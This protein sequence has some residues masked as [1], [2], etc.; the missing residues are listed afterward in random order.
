MIEF[1]R[2]EEEFLQSIE[3]ARIATSHADIP[4]VK[5]VSFI[6]HDNIIFIA[7]DYQTRTFKN[8]K[9]NPK[10][11]V[12]IDVYESGKHRAICIQ[13]KVKIIEEGQE[14]MQMY[15]MFENKFT[16]VRNEPWKENEAPFLKIITTN[17]TSWGL[18]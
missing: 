17:K 11:S 6:Y 8:I 2:G 18:K 3:E 7:T 1:T 12:A 13:G 16:W 14:F 4:H 15:K 5:P 10:A 9:I